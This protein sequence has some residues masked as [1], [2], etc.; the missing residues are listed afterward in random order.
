M[1]KENFKKGMLLLEGAFPK[2]IEKRS[3]DLTRDIY[4]RKLR[5][6]PDKIFEFAVEKAI[7]SLN[8]FPTIHQL[9]DFSELDT[10]EADAL[11]AWAEVVDQIGPI[12][13]YGIPKFSNP[14][15]M[16]TIK[17]IGGWKMICLTETS[18]IGI[19]REAFL[20]AFRAFRSREIETAPLLTGAVHPRIS[21][22]VKSIGA[23][24]PKMLSSLEEKVVEW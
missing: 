6:M 5:E 20:K 17:A 10:S 4:W 11:D 12:G 8:D 2:W 15:A 23:G 22:L 16:Q 13:S 21:G 18:K 3:K 19:Q 7:E 9:K 14:C 24:K 1:T